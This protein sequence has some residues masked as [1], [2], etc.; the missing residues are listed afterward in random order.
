[1]QKATGKANNL[2]GEINM[3]RQNQTMTEKLW[4][5]GA[6]GFISDA[7]RVIDRAKKCGA[8]GREYLLEKAEANLALAEECIKNTI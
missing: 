1:L 5:E 4:L 6:A 8:L 3:G 7:K 2:K